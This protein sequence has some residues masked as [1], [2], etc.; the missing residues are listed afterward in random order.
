LPEL[1]ELHTEIEIAAPPERV[2][3]VLTDFGSYPEWNPFIR[4]ISGQPAV[5]SHLEVRLEL[6]E[7]RAIT[8]NPSVLKAEP[9]QELAWLGRLVVPGIFDG[10]HHLQLQPRDGGTLFVQRE[11]FRGVLVPFV[12]GVLEKTRRGFVQMNAALKQRAEP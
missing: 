3:E 1:K 11:A 2:W 7:G 12:G 9:N 5:G 10:E 6:P 8:M 4:Q